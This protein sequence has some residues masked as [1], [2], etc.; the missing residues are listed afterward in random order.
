M[1]PTR[2]WAAHLLQLRSRAA[3]LRGHGEVTEATR[4]LIDETLGSCEELLEDFNRSQAECGRLLDESRATP[5][6]HKHLFES[7]PCACVMTDQQGTIVHA[8]AAAGQL[9]N[10]T[11]KRLEGRELLLYSHN[12]DAFLALLANLPSSE[13][14]SGPMIMRPRERRPLQTIVT[15]TPVNHNQPGVWLWFFVAAS[16]LAP[17]ETV[18][19]ALIEE[20]RPPAA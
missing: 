6:A 1:L 9:L 17:M 20:P 11:S 18:G 13:P 12:R 3:K 10:I 15:V 4:R 19:A 16:R 14:V 5:Q 7:V 8:N 2:Q